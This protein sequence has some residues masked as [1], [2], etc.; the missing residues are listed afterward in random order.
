MRTESFFWLIV[1]FIII[2]S[3]YSTETNI[4]NTYGYKDEED[5]TSR[6]TFYENGKW[7]E[8]SCSN[9]TCFCNRDDTVCKNCSCTIKRKEENRERAPGNENSKSLFILEFTFLK[10]SSS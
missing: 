7:T 3:T 1:A 4:N 2:Y 9:D 5:F 10:S 6:F 8:F